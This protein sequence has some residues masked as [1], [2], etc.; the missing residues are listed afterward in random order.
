MPEPTSSSSFFPIIPLGANVIL[1][2]LQEDKT[3]SGLLL[4]STENQ[5]IGRGE[6]VSGSLD[7]CPSCKTL[8]SPAYSVGTEVLFV[9]AAA[10]QLMIESKPYLFIPNNAI[11]AV[12][13]ASSPV[14][15]PAKAP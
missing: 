12:V 6:I 13:P 14:D 2:E 9:K 5:K 11:L 1:K 10:E 4:A 8:Y 7:I 15:S 3:A